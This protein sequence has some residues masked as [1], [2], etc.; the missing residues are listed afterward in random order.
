MKKNGKK[1]VKINYNTR[2]VSLSQLFQNFVVEISF[3]IRIVIILEF[4]LVKSLT[5]PWVCIDFI[6]VVVESIW[7]PVIDFW[8]PC[9]QAALW[10]GRMK[11]HARH[12]PQHPLTSNPSVYLSAALPSQKPFNPI[13]SF[14]YL[15]TVLY[16]LNL[17]NAVSFYLHQTYFLNKSSNIVSA[18]PSW[19]HFRLPNPEISRYPHQI[20]NYGNLSPN[21]WRSSHS[22]PNPTQCDSNSRPCCGLQTSTEIMWVLWR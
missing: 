2:V 5:W 19:C 17:C 13:L 8:F 10:R 4:T 15:S 1:R 14:Y 6:R 16:L 22:S 3:C 12:W 9:D 11:N 21:R 20:N 7:E 18:A